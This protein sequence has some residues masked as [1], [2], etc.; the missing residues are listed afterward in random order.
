MHSLCVLLDDYQI[1]KCLTSL[2]FSSHLGY[3]NCFT[4]D[5]MM[6]ATLGVIHSPDIWQ[7]CRVINSVRCRLIVHYYLSEHSSYTV[8]DISALKVSMANNLL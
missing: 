5:G 6:C 8:L 3:A 4:V 2:V 7:G 1:T